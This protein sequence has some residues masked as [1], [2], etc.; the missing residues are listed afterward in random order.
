MQATLSTTLESKA[1]RRLRTPT[2]RT[3]APL[4]CDVPGK[5]AGRLQ[6]R[7][8]LLQIHVRT[9]QDGDPA[10]TFLRGKV[11]LSA[12][13]DPSPIHL[14]F[15][16][17]PPSLLRELGGGPSARRESWANAASAYYL[18]T[19]LSGVFWVLTGMTITWRREL[20]VV[21]VQTFPR[22]QSVQRDARRSRA[23]TAREQHRRCPTLGR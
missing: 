22:P 17:G 9:A 13:H 8:R 19:D 6:V 20:A 14:S 16:I 5:W 10:S 18:G 4:G 12:D 21:L 3:A 11:S 1:M 7:A 23:M 2:I 15:A